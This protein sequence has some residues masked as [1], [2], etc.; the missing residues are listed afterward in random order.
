MEM[1]REA[2]SFTGWRAGGSGGGGQKFWMHR[3]GGGP[4]GSEKFQILNFLE[5]LGK[6][7]GHV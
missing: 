5:S 6:I 3:E 4:G 7:K 1:I 2:S